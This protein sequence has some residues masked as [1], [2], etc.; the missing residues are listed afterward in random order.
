ML[1][2][3]LKEAGTKHKAENLYFTVTKAI[4]LKNP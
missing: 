1:V 2:L 3:K 4:A